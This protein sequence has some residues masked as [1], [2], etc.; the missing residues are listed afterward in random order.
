MENAAII[1]DGLMA[2]GLTVYGGRNA[3]Y[4]WIR[5]P[6]GLS[7][8]DFFDKL[9]AEAHVVGMPGSGFGPSGEGYFRLTAFGS[10]EQT[11]EAVARISARL[12][13]GVA[14]P[15]RPRPSRRRARDRSASRP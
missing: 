1:R 3:Q 13:S 12:L 10:R 4:L 8:W 5:T 15:A 11:E 9:L 6:A 2:D 14:A 7:S